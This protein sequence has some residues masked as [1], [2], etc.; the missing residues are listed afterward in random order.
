M[1]VQKESKSLDHHVSFWSISELS[2]EMRAEFWEG[3]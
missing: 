2:S 3:F 1:S